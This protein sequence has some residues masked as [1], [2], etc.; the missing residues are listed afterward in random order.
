MWLLNS[1]DYQ[2]VYLLQP[3]SGL[4]CKCECVEP[5]IVCGGY[6][7]D[8]ESGP[9]SMYC[10]PPLIIIRTMSLKWSQT[11]K[12]QITAKIYEHLLQEVVH[13]YILYINNNLLSKKKNK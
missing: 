12:Q 11:Q 7:S 3:N 9:T 6:L 4:W 13:I 2:V 8:A 10:F 5:V 1:K